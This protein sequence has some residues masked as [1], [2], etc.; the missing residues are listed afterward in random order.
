MKSYKNSNCQAIFGET[1]QAKKPKTFPLCLKPDSD[2]LW[3]WGG[4][5]CLC[6]DTSKKYDSQSAWLDDTSAWAAEE[7]SDWLCDAN[8]CFIAAICLASWRVLFFKF[9]CWLLVYWLWYQ[10]SVHN[11]SCHVTL[12]FKPVFES[13]HYIFMHV[14]SMSMGLMQHSGLKVISPGDGFQSWGFHGGHSDLILTQK[15]LS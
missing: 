10:S 15:N 4:S 8:D 2:Y 14:I 12:Q 11:V 7:L 3:S 1:K 9:F 5:L 6:S 13:T